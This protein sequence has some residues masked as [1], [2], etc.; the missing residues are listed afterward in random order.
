MNQYFQNMADEWVAM[1]TEAIKTRPYSEQEGGVADILIRELEKIGV[2]NYR[3]EAGN[4]IGILKGEEGGPTVLLNGHMD[5]VPEGNLAAWG[6]HDPFDPV[7]EDG[8]LYGRGTTDMLQGLFSQF[9][10]FR[11]IKRFV[12]KGGSFKGTL[13]FSGVVCEEP[14]ESMGA[15][16]LFENTLPK[17]DIKPDVV[18]LSEPTAGDL[19]IGQRGKVELVVDV[20]GKVAHSSAP[21]Q[22]ISAVEKA[23][24]LIEAVMNNFYKTSVVHEKLGFGAM[25]ITDIEVKPGRMYSCVPDHCSITIDRRYVPPVTIPDTIK[26]VQDFIDFMAAKDPD[27]KAEVHQRINF[28]KGYTGFGLDVKKQHPAWINDADNKYVKR[29]FEV[30]RSIGQDPQE[31]YFIG[32]TDGSI[33]CGVYGIPTIIY[34]FGDLNLSHQPGEYCI[35]VNEMKEIEGHTALI[36]DSLGVD[37]NCICE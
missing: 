36:C 22:G 37:L 34:S 26:E 9:F 24:P 20:F 23:M 25:T 19:Y 18:Y 27:F 33:T 14:A 10:A 3:D 8:R 30:L 4:V 12:D 32:G 5:F 1:M 11:E 28:R 29:A 7:V 16:Y 2:Q 6:G 13:V 21:W 15:I 17:F 31:R 35:I